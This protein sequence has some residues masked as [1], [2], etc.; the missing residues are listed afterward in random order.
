MSD[1]ELKFEYQEIM[2]GVVVSP[3]LPDE[4]NK[5]KTRDIVRFFLDPLTEK[6]KIEITKLGNK[7]F[8]FVE[9]ASE[10]WINK[11][12]GPYQA[13]R[14]NAKEMRPD[15]TLLASIG[16]IDAAVRRRL[17]GAKIFSLEALVSFPEANLMQ[18]GPGMKK[19]RDK[20]LESLKEKVRLANIKE[21]N[22][23]LRERVDFM[24]NLL[25]DKGILEEAEKKFEQKEEEAL[26][27][28]ASA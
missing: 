7:D 23:S 11:Y 5:K 24:M 22:D 21:E 17:E 20:A 26:P 2:P 19:I 10:F 15:E 8:L 6:E 12:P 25:E 13:Y 16:W 4:D 18:F 3:G 1:Q 28:L 27:Q 14:E 9:E